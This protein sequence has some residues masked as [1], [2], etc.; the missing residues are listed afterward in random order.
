MYV[1]VYTSVEL[2]VVHVCRASAM[3]HCVVVI[4]VAVV[5]VS[6]VVVGGNNT[7]ISGSSST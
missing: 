6:A 2:H 7:S 3:A 1:I 5:V 4:A